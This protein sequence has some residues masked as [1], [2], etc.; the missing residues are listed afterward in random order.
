MA[1]PPYCIGM[2]DWTDCPGGLQLDASMPHPTTNDVTVAPPPP[3][4]SASTSRSTHTRTRTP[5]L[6]TQPRLL[7]QTVTRFDF[8]TSEEELSE[9]AKGLVP[10]NTAKNTQWA[11][12]NFEDWR[13]TRN[14]CHPENP[15]PEDILESC[16]PDIINVQ[17]SRFVVETRKSKGVRYP[18]STLHQL[19]CGL[20]RCMR[21]INPDCPN[22]LYKTRQQV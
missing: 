20:L 1:C 10:Q 11:V 15:V 3:A 21:E 18:R 13:K 14:A 7:S 17:L 6:G 22:F 4:P 8:T 5:I 2:C 12:K 16:D 19:L 9:L